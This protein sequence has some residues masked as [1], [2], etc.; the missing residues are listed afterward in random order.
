MKNQWEKIRDEFP[1]ANN[2]IFFDNA[3]VAPI[4]KRT[5]KVVSA[6]AEDICNFGTAH[7][8]EWM[9]KVQ[10][11][12]ESFARL[13]G[14]NPKEVAFVKNTSEGLSIVANGI[15]WRSGENVVIPNI[16]FPANVYPWQN[17]ERHGVETRMVSC[18]NGRV[19]FEKL[20][21]A[22]DDKTRILSISSVECNSGFLNDL[23]RLGEFCKKKKIYFCVDA[24]QSLG[25]LP[26]DVNNFQID[27]LAADGHKW[28][29]SVEGLGGFYINSK[30]LDEIYP[31]VVGWNSVDDAYNF[32][33]YDFTF[34]PD[35]RRFEE[36]TFN[37]M[38][39]QALGASL[40]IFHE[41]G[42][43]N[44]KNRILE[45]GDYLIEGIKKRNLSIYN[46]E[47][48]N[49]RSGIITFHFGDQNILTF[50]NE[51]NLVLTVR[52]GLVR[53]SPHIYN[54]EEEADIFFD[55][56]DSYLSK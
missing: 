42:M 1:V 52:D 9:I 34:R 45:L 35:A 13:I 3:R 30:L 40:S 27:F 50:M 31:T 39:I 28:L 49:E 20:T 37:S 54:T 12:R 23:A 19:D 4:P 6:F 16:E 53:L 47:K 21:E 2:Q 44:V 25:A 26:L 8:S 36:G 11:T 48:I 55:V 56:L 38:S 46:S 10:E 22:V 41:I 51:N 18:S 15:N 5:Q 32:M 29:L 43:E 14:A 7:Y 33:T 17:L 24:I